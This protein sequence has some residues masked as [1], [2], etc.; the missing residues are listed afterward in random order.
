MAVYANISIDQGSD[1]T[2]IITV[3]GNDGLVFN[4]TG[5]LPRGQIRKSYASLTAVD[6]TASILSNVGGT[7]TISL[8]NAE[9]L[10]M[11]AGRYVYDIEVKHTASGI[12]T[13]IA[14]G[15]LEINPCVTQPEEE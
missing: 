3:E 8:D 2:S 10:A 15:N 14:E 5:Y 1:F 6:F 4:L 7:I 12:V 13:R 9:T 11:K